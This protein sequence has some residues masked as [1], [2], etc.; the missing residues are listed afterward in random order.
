MQD[1]GV[2]IFTAAA[3]KSALKKAIKRKQ[4]CVNGQIAST[5][6]YIEEGDIIELRIPLTETKHKK[7]H[8]NLTC[9][10]EDEHLAIVHKPAGVLTSGNA[11]KTIA[12]ALPNHLK[13]SK[14]PD[15]ILPQPAH[16]LDFPTTGLL[17]VGKTSSALQK[18]NKAFDSQK[19]KKVY[20]AICI[21]SLPKYGSIDFAIDGKEAKTFYNVL[22]TV[23]SLRFGQLQLVQLLPIT[24]RR[25]QLRKHLFAMN[26]PILG[27]PIY[28]NK[29]HIL[30]GKGL[31]LHAYSL[32]FTHPKTEDILDIKDRLPSKFNKIFNAI[33]LPTDF[34][35]R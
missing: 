32:R 17:V 20:Y 34:L 23:A 1:Y 6:M 29:N 28:H 21:G 7:F 4:I 26:S 3:S 35:L 10:Y 19:V 9:L 22:G 18:L 33:S 8:L 11:F 25:H 27:D 24:G 13:T 2:G 15:A 12:N 30:K 31:Y 5:A 16:R 14:E